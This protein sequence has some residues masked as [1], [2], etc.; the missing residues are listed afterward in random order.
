MAIIEEILYEYQVS[1]DS[2]SFRRR[3]YQ[4]QFAKLAVQDYMNKYKIKAEPR[5]KRIME[6]T[7]I[8][9]DKT[10]WADFYMFIGNLLLRNYLPKKA[11]QYYMKSLKNG[12]RNCLPYIYLCNIG[13]FSSS[14][15]NFVG[16]HIDSM[17]RYKVS[18][19]SKEFQDV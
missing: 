16:N 14:L 2:V 13:R 11:K 9:D 1:V 10:V 12:K 8:L 7:D 3:K 18:C 17:W 6:N 19:I 5:I 4:E 15:T